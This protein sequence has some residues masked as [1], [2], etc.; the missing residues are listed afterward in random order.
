MDIIEHG[1]ILPADGKAKA[2]VYGLQG[3]LTEQFEDDLISEYVLLIFVNSRLAYK[4][5]GPS[6]PCSRKAHHRS[7][8]RSF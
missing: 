8:N 3:E 4:A 7:G 2:S 1:D 5:D 6:G